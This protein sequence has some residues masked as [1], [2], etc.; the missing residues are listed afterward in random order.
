MLTRVDLEARVLISAL[1]NIH[2]VL[3][4]KIR[5]RAC[6]LVLVTLRCEHILSLAGK[7]PTIACE[8]LESAWEQIYLPSDQHLGILRELVYRAWRNAL[9]RFPSARAYEDAIYARSPLLPIEP[10]IWGLTGLA[11]VGK[12][13]LICALVRA[14]QPPEGFA[15]ASSVT[16]RC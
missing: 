14:I 3:R 12:S 7:S 9:H 4:Q 8:E 11:G 10:E 5:N 13:S 1:R 16:S 2:Q 15:V 6:L